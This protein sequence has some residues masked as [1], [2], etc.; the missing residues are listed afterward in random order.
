M[1]LLQPF[2]ILDSSF[3]I[4]LFL[5]SFLFWSQESIEWKIQ[6]FIFY[7]FVFLTNHMTTIK[8]C[9]ITYLKSLSN[10][11]CI[12]NIYA[13]QKELRGIKCNGKKVLPGLPQLQNEAQTNPWQTWDDW[14]FPK[15]QII[16]PRASPKDLLTWAMWVRLCSPIQSNHSP[17]NKQTIKHTDQVKKRE[18][19][20]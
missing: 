4:F 5:F 13:K 9:S 11:V 19:A 3:S 12:H 10:K 1:I 15:P 8:G 6:N 16:C 17:A 7:S 20:K 2:D 14:R 18:K